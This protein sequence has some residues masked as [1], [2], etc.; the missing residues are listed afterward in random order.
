MSKMTHVLVTLAL[1]TSSIA[2]GA[3]SGEL[4]VA[5]I[6]RTPTHVFDNMVYLSGERAPGDFRV[7]KALRVDT[8][9]DLDG[10]ADRDAVERAGL[11]YIHIPLER[12]FPANLDELSPIMDSITGAAP[13]RRVVVCDDDGEETGAVWT[14]YRA[15]VGGVDAD[16]ALDEGRSIG[17][18]DRRLVRHIRNLVAGR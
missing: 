4:P 7:F 1:S 13:D 3:S 18:D 6:G 16:T 11:R 8:V 10:T 9:I 5:N 12:G 17:L 15:F 14:L 2:A